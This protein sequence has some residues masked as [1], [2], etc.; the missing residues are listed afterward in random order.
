MRPGTP[1][2]LIAAFF[3]SIL[4]LIVAIPFAYPPGTF[5]GLDGTSGVMDHRWSAGQ[6][7]YAIGDMFCHQD[8]DRSFILNGSQTAFCTRDIGIMAGCAAGLV[9]TYPLAGRYPFTDRKTMYL[10]LALVM[11]TVA[12]WAAGAMIGYDM[13]LLRFSSGAVG[14]L[15]IAMVIQN[16][17]SEPW[18]GEGES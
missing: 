7:V 16:V 3:F 11:V 6:F 12:E 8:M 1:I 5:T 9:A 4:A 17:A 10:G 13:D 18:K 14:G 2:L 15:G